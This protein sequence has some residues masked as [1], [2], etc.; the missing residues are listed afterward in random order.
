MPRPYLVCVTN[1]PILYL[2]MSLKF[3]SSSLPTTSN[4]DL[5]N[6]VFKFYKF[7]KI[8]LRNLICLFIPITTDIFLLINILIALIKN[9]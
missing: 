5:V 6:K 2:M 7:R 3:L 1:V 9:V 8:I 4:V